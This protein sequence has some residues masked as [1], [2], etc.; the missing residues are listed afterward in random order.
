MGISAPLGDA[1]SMSKG[2]SGRSGQ[3]VRDDATSAGFGLL[4]QHAGH[5]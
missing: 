3:F 5:R 1:A 4:W 2:H